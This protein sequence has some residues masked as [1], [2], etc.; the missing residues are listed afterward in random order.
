M[1]AIES[2]SSSGTYSIDGDRI[3]MAFD[4]GDSLGE[5]FSGRWS[6][7]RDT[8]V[9]ERVPGEVLPTPFLVRAWTRVQ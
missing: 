6:L 4:E 2:S 1:N 8:L 9:F 7:F 5:T 3:V